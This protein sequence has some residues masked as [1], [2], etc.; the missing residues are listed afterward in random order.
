EPISF[1]R[2]A[3]EGWTLQSDTLQRQGRTGSM[4]Q[5]AWEKL[6]RAA[7]GL[8]S[9]QAWGALVDGAL[10]ASLITTRIDDTY[11]V[12]YAQSLRQYLNCHVNNAL[13]FTVCC[14]LLGQAG[15][16]GIFFCLHSLDARETVDQF[17][18][19]MNFTPTPVRQRVVFHPAL[20]PLAN[21]LTHRAVQ[22]L[23]QRAPE[24][25]ALS[26]AE[27]ML[28]FNVQGKLPPERQDWPDCLLESRPAVLARIAAAGRPAGRPDEQAR[29]IT[30]AS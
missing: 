1:E 14:D 5:A 13:F 25:Y 24:N 26:K 17:K 2:L 15:V 3:G 10:A 20:A 19:R 30:E 22:S 9:F 27:G 11:Y 29:Q 4:S 21:R 28:R 12:P 16:N 8:P 6:C 7:E 23:H 18:F